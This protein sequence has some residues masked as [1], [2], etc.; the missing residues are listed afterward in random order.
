[1]FA[2]IS[3]LE[4]TLKIEGRKQI[5]EGVMNIQGRSL[6][7]SWTEACVSR[8]HRKYA[9]EAVLFSLL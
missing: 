2:F 5:K 3:A 7:C 1:M 8:T 9:Q 4:E 6:Y